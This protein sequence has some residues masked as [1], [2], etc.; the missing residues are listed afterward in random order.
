MEIHSNS[1]DERR[2]TV[3]QLSN[4]N[5]EGIFTVS[6]MKGGEDALAQGGCWTSGEIIFTKC[7]VR[8]DMR[9]MNYLSL[10]VTFILDDFLCN[11]WRSFFTSIWCGR[12]EGLFEFS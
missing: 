8:E 9:S 4:S 12:M 10:S 3:I 1:T 5:L 7:S 2:L 6:P 11:F